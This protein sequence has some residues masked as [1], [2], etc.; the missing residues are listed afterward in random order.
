[1]AGIILARNRLNPEGQGGGA[2]WYPDSPQCLVKSRQCVGVSRGGALSHGAPTG[3][4]DNTPT[5]K[6]CVNKDFFFLFASTNK[7]RNKL[8]NCPHPVQSVCECTLSLQGQKGSMVSSNLR[9]VLAQAEG[10]REV[11][12]SWQAQSCSCPKQPDCPWGSSRP[13]CWLGREVSGRSWH[14]EAGLLQDLSG[15][16]L[17]K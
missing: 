14:G 12:I 2:L 3:P 11:V 15:E 10:R 13:W 7:L 9:V 1:M 4:T 17:A 5:G 16:G 8:E 6:L